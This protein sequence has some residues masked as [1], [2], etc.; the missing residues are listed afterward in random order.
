[1]ACKEL[2]DRDA[3]SPDKQH[4]FLPEVV[5]LGKIKSAVLLLARNSLAHLNGYETPSFPNPRHAISLR[6]C[7]RDSAIQIADSVRSAEETLTCRSA[8]AAEA[9]SH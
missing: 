3:L 2:C 4:N 1:M 6:A 8:H 5:P 7:D 9:R